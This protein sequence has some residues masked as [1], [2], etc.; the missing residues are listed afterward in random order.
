[1]KIA[2]QSLKCLLFRFL[3][4]VDR[5]KKIGYNYL[6]F[7]LQE[8]SKMSF[9]VTQNTYLDQLKNYDLAAY[10]S[11]SFANEYLNSKNALEFLREKVQ[12]EFQKKDF[13]DGFIEQVKVITSSS[14][15][16]SEL[17]REVLIA[18]GS[19]FMSEEVDRDLAFRLLLR[20]PKYNKAKGVSFK[21]TPEFPD[22]VAGGL[23]NLGNTCWFNSILQQFFMMDGPMLRALERAAGSPHHNNRAQKLL[24][25]VRL[26]KQKPTYVINEVLNKYLK[27]FMTDFYKNSFL[28]GEA[29]AT[30]QD[31]E[32]GFNALLTYLGFEKDGSPLRQELS[33]LSYSNLRRGLEIEPFQQRI[34]HEPTFLTIL[35]HGEKKQDSVQNL[36]TRANMSFEVLTGDEK[37]YF[38]RP[39]DEKEEAIKVDYFTLQG[40]D[41]EE[42]SFVAPRFD[43]E[44]L[45]KDVS[46]LTFDQQVQLDIY[47]DGGS[48]IEKRLSLR[49][50]S[51]VCHRGLSSKSGHYVTLKPDP[52]GGYTLYNDSQISHLEVQKAQ[53]YLKIGGYIANYSVIGAQAAFTE[54]RREG[55]ITVDLV[56]QTYHELQNIKEVKQRASE[57][58]RALYKDIGL[59]ATACLCF[60]ISY[61]SANYS[62]LNDYLSSWW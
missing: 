20:S 62:S 35:R 31:A 14:E 33:L 49:L 47:N 56:Q 26:A 39:S 38:D 12:E 32:E 46:P 5:V 22:R 59:L 16:T 3:L 8:C 28:Q 21:K 4:S 52:K 29:R 60:Y 23:F 17:A 24:E 53:E 61:C 40:E 43:R 10:G 27:A 7:T 25:I 19:A 42:I 13:T 54:R 37:V 44:T 41:P 48:R 58:R 15:V 9:P 30:Q 1:M 34:R 55:H 11:D 36:V 45:Q 2:F 18:T 51:I 6:R 57:Y 50:K